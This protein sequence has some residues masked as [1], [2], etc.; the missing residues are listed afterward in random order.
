MILGQK[1]WPRVRLRSS[2]GHLRF[3]AKGA[4]CGSGFGV[5]LVTYD[6]WPKEQAACQASD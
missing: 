3:L 4:G 1:C 6:F 5:V 2:F